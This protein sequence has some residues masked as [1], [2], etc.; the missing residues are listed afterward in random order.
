MKYFVVFL[1]L[2]DQVF[3]SVFNNQLFLIP[4]EQA[5]C[6]NTMEIAKKGEQCTFHVILMSI[7]SYKWDRDSDSGEPQR[8]L[9]PNTSQK[10][11]GICSPWVDVTHQGVLQVA[12]THVMVRKLM[13]NNSSLPENPCITPSQL[14]A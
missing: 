13:A 1:S 5:F 14:G 10:S 8:T 9:S 3:W 2:K 6:F 12:K 7:C 4:W 11:L